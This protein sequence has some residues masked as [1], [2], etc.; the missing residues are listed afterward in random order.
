M[1]QVATYVTYSQVADDDRCQW[2][3]RCAAG[4]ADTPM[5]AQQLDASVVKV[6]KVTSAVAGL[7]L[8]GRIDAQV[9]RMAGANERYA[10]RGI[11]TGK[12]E[13]HVVSQPFGDPARATTGLTT[14]V[15][16][17]ARPVAALRVCA[18]AP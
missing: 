3:L 10:A 18:P 6:A 16:P 15:A 7:P 9:S 11:K 14:S 12:T 13:S 8:G 2:I 4:D 1:G 5:S 17:A